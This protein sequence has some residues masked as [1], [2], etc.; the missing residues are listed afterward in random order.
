M[1]SDSNGIPNQ[2]NIERITE[3]VVYTGVFLP[4]NERERLLQLVTPKF[5]KVI[6]HHVTL[7]FRPTDGI[8]K[9]DIG[10]TVSLK[11]TGQ[12]INDA[13]GAQAVLVEL[14][15]GIKCSNKNP[16]ITISVK[17]DVPP[18]KSNEAID[19]ALQEGTVINF[20]N[21]IILNAPQGFFNGDTKQI[22]TS[23]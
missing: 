16:H 3:N 11:I 21:P 15:E 8:S 22:V 7:A 13:I 1:L 12:V 14:P 9:Q 23:L 20:E 18:V 5:E 10:K 4:E 17:P 2:E 19:K 6:A